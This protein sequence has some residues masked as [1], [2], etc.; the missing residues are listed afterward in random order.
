MEKRGKKPLP[1]FKSPLHRRFNGGKSITGEES[2]SPAVD[3][4]ASC[5]EEWGKIPYIDIYN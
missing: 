4:S 2:N 1:L 3:P 5:F